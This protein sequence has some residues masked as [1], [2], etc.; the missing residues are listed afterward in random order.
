[1]HGGFQCRD[2]AAEIVREPEDKEKR[3]HYRD[4]DYHDI[5]KQYRVDV[6][7]CSAIY[8]SYQKDII[9]AVRA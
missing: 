1:M 5:E 9:G 7:I 2:T 4:R 6:F 3:Q 8:R